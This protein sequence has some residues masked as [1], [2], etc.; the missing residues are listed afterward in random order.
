MGGAYVHGCVGVVCVYECG[1]GV[2]WSGKCSK[3]QS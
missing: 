3:R 1:G 2:C